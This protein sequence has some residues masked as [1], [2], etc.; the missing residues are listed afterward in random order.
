MEK[1]TINQN[2][3]RKSSIKKAAKMIA[4]GKIVAIPTETVYGLAA[5]A[6]RKDAVERLYSLKKR[7]IDKPFSIVLADKNIAADKYFLTLPPFGYRLIEHF[8]PGPLTIVSYRKTEG[9]VGIRIPSN[10][11]T[12]S[13]LQQLDFPVFLPSAN[14]SGQKEATSASEV[15]EIFDGN[16]DLI[17][18]AGGI[19]YKKPSTVIDLTYKPFKILREGVISEKEIVSIFIKK[20]L[21]F[22]CTGNRCRSPMAE[23]LL[24][25][26]LQKEKRASSQRYQIISAGTFAPEGA[27][28]PQYLQKIMKSEE[29]IDISGSK[30]TKLTKQ[31][32]LS[33]DYIFTME[34]SQ[35]EYILKQVPSAAARVF[36]LNKFVAGGFSTDIPDPIGKNF[37]FYKNVYNLIKKAIIELVDWL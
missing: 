31:M 3:L 18:D 8:W 9:K 4:K 28:P 34:N 29:N 14:L 6:D 25:A 21:L 5:R 16:I 11:V 7:S 15:E 17:V 32:I 12:N 35:R 20:R 30:A 10:S 13:I 24:R 36:N 27:Q 26:Y 1:V 23:Y 19:N 2:D 33:A 22:V 37:I